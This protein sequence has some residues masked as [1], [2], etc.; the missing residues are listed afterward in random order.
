[1]GHTMPTGKIGSTGCY[2][3]PISPI[4]TLENKFNPRD[5]I[6]MPVVKF[7]FRLELGKIC[8]M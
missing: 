5:T 8:I 6:Y 3:T 2:T 7:I 4:S 1:M